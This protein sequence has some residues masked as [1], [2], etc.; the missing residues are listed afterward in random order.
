MKSATSIALFMTA[1]IE[2]AMM[3]CLTQKSAD[4]LKTIASLL[5]NL[6]NS[7]Q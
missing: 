7:L 6:L 4:P 2:G 3:L 1:S 5:P